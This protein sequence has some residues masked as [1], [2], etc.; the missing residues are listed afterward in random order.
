MKSACKNCLELK[1]TDKVATSC[2]C[3]ME[4]TLGPCKHMC[5]QKIKQ[6]TEK[7]KE[8]YPFLDVSGDIEFTRQWAHTTEE[9]Y[10]LSFDAQP[11]GSKGWPFHIAGNYFA[12]SNSAAFNLTEVQGVC[13]TG[14]DWHVPNVEAAIKSSFLEKHKPKTVGFLHKPTVTFGDES[15][16]WGRFSFDAFELELAVPEP[17]VSRKFNII[18]HYYYTGYHVKQEGEHKVVFDVERNY[19]N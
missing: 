11:S 7:F 16:T 1:P 8:K 17:K 10:A 12:S 14:M 6:V 2:F 18:G 15:K 13:G 4:C 3:T 19:D 5:P 9:I